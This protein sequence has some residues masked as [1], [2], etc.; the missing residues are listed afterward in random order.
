MIFTPFAWEITARPAKCVGDIVVVIVSLQVRLV[1]QLSSPRRPRSSILSHYSDF[2]WNNIF[3]CRCFRAFFFHSEM[4]SHN[5]PSLWTFF[6]II[7]SVEKKLR[8]FR[9]LCAF[10]DDETTLVDCRPALFLS[11]RR[12]QFVCVSTHF[13]WMSSENFSV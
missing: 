7:K 10:D 13:T 1:A 2:N 12:F 11:R 8:C 9:L 4:P 5:F 3:C 6:F